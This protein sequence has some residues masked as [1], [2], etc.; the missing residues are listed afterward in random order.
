VKTEQ[1]ILRDHLAAAGITDEERV[2]KA[3]GLFRVIRALDPGAFVSSA[4]RRVVV[5]ITKEMLHGRQPYV[6]HRTP[7][8]LL[9]APSGDAAVDEWERP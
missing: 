4:A 3:L 6:V 7:A 1:D 5:E 8:E 9:A 2:G